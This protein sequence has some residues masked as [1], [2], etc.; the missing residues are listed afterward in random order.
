MH[1]GIGMD[2][3]KVTSQVA[4][5]VD[6]K[7]T[8]TFKISHDLFGFNQLNKATSQFDNFPN[9]VFEATGVYSRILKASLDGTQLSL[10]LPEPFGC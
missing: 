5:A 9:I 7:V 1:Y 10:Y 3:S 2:A 4:V 6:G 8:Q